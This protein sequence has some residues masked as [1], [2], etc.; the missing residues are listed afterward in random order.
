[1]KEWINKLGNR[2]VKGSS[3]IKILKHPNFK[4]NKCI[5]KAQPFKYASKSYFD[6]FLSVKYVK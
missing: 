2:Q 1:M 4:V 3:K 5:K 6:I